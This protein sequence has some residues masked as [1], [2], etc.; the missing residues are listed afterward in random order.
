MN[1]DRIILE[2]LDRVSALEDH[3]AKLEEALSSD[4]QDRPV[5]E[6]SV[7]EEDTA[8]ASGRDTT[9]YL[10]NG[11]T[12]GKNRL[13][14]AVVQKYVR[15]HPNVSAEDLMS[16]FDKSLQGSF[17]VVRRLDGLKESHADY[18]HRFFTAPNEKIQTS[19]G[20]CLVS[21]QWGKPNIGA[22]LKR[23]KQLNY[24]IAEIK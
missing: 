11:K 23:A 13:V 2:L 15:E 21:T 7:D 9:K 22:F 16:T 20:I 19:T 12:Y 17:G 5:Y 14:L 4:Q 24:E 10:F 18:E 1:Y 3:V 6:T 8:K